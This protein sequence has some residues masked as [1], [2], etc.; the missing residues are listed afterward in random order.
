MPIRA[1]TNQLANNLPKTRLY[2]VSRLALRP[3]LSTAPRPSALSAYRMCSNHGAPPPQETAHAVQPVVAAVAP[4]ASA[5]PVE[6]SAAAAG[7]AKPVK[8]KKA[9]KAGIVGGMASLELE[10]KPEYLA[11]RIDLFEKWKKE[12]DDKIAGE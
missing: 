10:P 11:A 2:A 3:A 6:G 7:P 1:L 5:A 12:A 9:K 4:E 8:E